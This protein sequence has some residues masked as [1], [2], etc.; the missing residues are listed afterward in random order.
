MKMSCPTLMS[1]PQPLS[2]QASPTR[3]ISLASGAFVLLDY[4]DARIMAD[5]DSCLRIVPSSALGNWWYY[6]CCCCNARLLLF[7]SSSSSSKPWLVEASRYVVAV[8][9]GGTSVNLNSTRCRAERFQCH[10][11]VTCLKNV[12][13][14]VVE[15]E[16]GVMPCLHRLYLTTDDI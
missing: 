11:A 16:G 8:L 2:V 7:S 1:Q 4:R 13:T 10:F 3:R 12:S 9:L 15:A 5:W 14:C 6:Y